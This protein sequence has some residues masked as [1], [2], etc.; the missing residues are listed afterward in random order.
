[1]GALSEVIWPSWAPLSGE[2][3]ELGH[4]QIPPIRVPFHTC[5]AQGF[6]GSFD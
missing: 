6:I 4:A 5:S 1:M 3:D 2:G